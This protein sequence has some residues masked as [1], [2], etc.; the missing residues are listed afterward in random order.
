[1]VFVFDFCSFVLDIIDWIAFIEIVRNNNEH[2]THFI[3]EFYF[4]FYFIFR[5]ENKIISEFYSLRVNGAV[6]SR[7]VRTITHISRQLILFIYLPNEKW[8]PEYWILPLTDSFVRQCFAHKTESHLK[9]IL[10]RICATRQLLW[11][12]KHNNKFL[13]W[14]P[15]HIGRVNGWA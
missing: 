14:F 3:L 8:Q 15:R 1:M 11:K 12:Q 4:R 13:N 5:S 6:Y 7:Y 9:W 10:R 2:T